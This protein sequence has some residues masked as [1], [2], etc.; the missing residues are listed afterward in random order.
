VCDA[1]LFIL[2]IHISSLGASWRGEMQP[3]FSVWCGVG[4]A[5]HGL[6][7]QNVAEFDSGLMLCLLLVGKRKKRKEGRKEGRKE[8]GRKKKKE[9]AGGL[10][11]QG[12]AHL[13]SCAAQ[14]FHHC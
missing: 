2:Q 13:V 3:L 11:F 7:V 12:W 4:S 14:D 8:E 1:Y 6:G 10:F 5:F 9:M